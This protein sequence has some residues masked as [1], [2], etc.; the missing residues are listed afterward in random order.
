MCSKLYDPHNILSHDRINII[1]AGS[2]KISDFE[3]WDIKKRLVCH[4][5][6]KIT[7]QH[8]DF[9]R[10][11][12]K[13]FIILDSGAFSAWTKG[14][15]INIDE[16]TLK[17][18]EYSDILNMAANLDVIPGSRGNRQITESQN[19]EAAI[20]GWKN[21]IYILNKLKWHGRE[22][23]TTRIM[24]IHHQG[25]KLDVL[26]RMIDYGC[27][28]VGISP[29]NDA[30]TIQR[31]KYLDEVFSYLLT[32]PERILTHGYAVTSEVLMAKYPWFTV[33]SISWI[34]TA[35]FGTVKTPFGSFCF[36]EDPRSLKNKENLLITFDEDG[37]WTIG[38]PEY[39]HL[40]ND[41]EQ[42]LVEQLMIDPH[43]LGQDYWARAKA[44]IL[45]LQEFERNAILRN[46]IEHSTQIL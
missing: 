25:E 12:P 7:Y 44:N 1:F 32:L 23:L 37:S 36:S 10:S 13:M 33:D 9:Y 18:I 30:T 41:L 8:L 6:T 28:Y 5:D 22:D 35:G 38:N 40:K 21:Y 2:V 29:S 31:I 34:Y 15:E 17:I 4:E 20:A 39:Q 27:T 43:S 42:Y 16:F 11:M 46:K 45:Y 24:P 14:A 26:K 3:G 19:E